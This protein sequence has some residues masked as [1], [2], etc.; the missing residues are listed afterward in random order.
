MNYALKVRKFFLLALL[1]FCMSCSLLGC[2][3][4]AKTSNHVSKIGFY[5]NTVI[6]ITLYDSRQE[7]L[8]DECFSIAGRYEKMFSAT[9]DTSEISQINH[10]KG[11]PVTV[12]DETLALIKKGI[13]Y[14]KLSEGGF[15]ITIGALSSLWN[16]SENKGEI[17]SQAS[18]SKAVSTIGYQN[19]CIKGNEVWLK[20]PDASL[21]LGGIA[22]GYIADRIKEYLNDHNAMAGTINL[23]GN[24]L[25]LGTDSNSPIYRIGIQKP[26]EEAGTAAAVVEV[27]DE[28]V[29]SSGVYERYITV[30]GKRYHHILNPASGYPYDNGLLGVTIICENSVDGD[31]LSTA[32]FTLGL[33]KGLE[34]IESIENA[35]A[36][37]ITTDYSFHTSSGIGDA[38]PF[39]VLN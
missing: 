26:F 32:C 14:S 5:L 21:D 11:S 16:F 34:L 18:I 33:D 38:V 1:L 23:G 27:T 22:K 30:D 7:Y 24:V 10:A 35:E 19:I 17:P 12:S 39:Q 3:L 20:N 15:D 31:G 4:P 25:C 8:I 36:I 13:E 37:F 2:K 9:I 29:V 6:T 28:T